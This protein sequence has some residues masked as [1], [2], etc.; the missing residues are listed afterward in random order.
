MTGLVGGADNLV[1][2]LCKRAKKALNFYILPERFSYKIYA[3][4]VV[5]YEIFLFDTIL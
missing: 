5:K 2:N 1:Q 4:F 3:N